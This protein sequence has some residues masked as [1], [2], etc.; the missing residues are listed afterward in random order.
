VLAILLAAR[1]CAVPGDHLLGQI[2]RFLSGSACFFSRCVSYRLVP[3]PD[4]RSRLHCRFDRRPLCRQLPA[5][6]HRPYET[7][8]E[9][10][11]S[12]ELEKMP[13]E[14]LPPIEKKLV[15]WSVLLGLFLPG[16]LVWV[17]Q[18]VSYT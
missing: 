13:Y 16:T 5:G 17:N 12:E 8:E 2:A 10:N 9:P 6:L 4:Q 14:P 7:V 18:A 15:L 1:G 11:L 3:Q